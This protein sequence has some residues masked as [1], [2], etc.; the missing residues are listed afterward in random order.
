[1]D[2]HRSVD[3]E[4]ETFPLDRLGDQAPIG[5]G[6]TGMEENRHHPEPPGGGAAMPRTESSRASNR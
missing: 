2:R 6:P 5:F 1:M 4:P 3:Q